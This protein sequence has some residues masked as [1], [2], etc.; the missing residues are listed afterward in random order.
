MRNINIIIKTWKCSDDWIIRLF[1]ELQETLDNEKSFL[2]K[3][4]TNNITDTRELEYF[5][6][7]K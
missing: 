1:E 5:I 3:D 2:K 6:D 7:H 4:T